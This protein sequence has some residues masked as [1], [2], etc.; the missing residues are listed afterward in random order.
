MLFIRSRKWLLWGLATALLLIVANHGEYALF[1]RAEAARHISAVNP[2][3]QQED[4]TQGHNTIGIDENTLPEEETSCFLHFSTLGLWAYERQKPVACP[5]PIQALSGQRCSS[6]G[7]MYPLDSGLQVKTFCLLRSTQ[8]CCYGPRPQWNQFLLV[9]TPVPVPLERLAPVLV[10][11]TFYVEPKPE[12]GYV[13]RMAA[14]SV[15]VIEGETPDI[16]PV[17]AAKRAGLPL[18]DYAAL[19]GLSM[20]TAALPPSLRALE[21]RTVVLAGYCVRRS[22]DVPPHLVV[23]H[24]WWDG[25]AQGEPPTVAN[26]VQV[27]PADAGQVPPLWK[28]FQVYTGRLH[29]RDEPGDWPREG[30][31]Q[32]EAAHLGAPGALPTTRARRNGPLVPWQIEA[33]LLACVLL[34]TLGWQRSLSGSAARPPLSPRYVLMGLTLILA[35]LGACSW[36]MAWTERAERDTALAGAILEQRASDVMVLLEQG[37]NPNF[38]SAALPTEKQEGPEI[39]MLLYAVQ[40]SE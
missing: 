12:D 19:S 2:A 20:Q 28:P 40:R 33:G 11:G 16:D 36:A 32:L 27:R 37:A 31:V 6:V 5:Q 4:G 38:L 30:I 21:G 22:R 34:L 15:Q 39:P 9:E 26:S 10:N 14:D 7:F 23:S 13:Y 29:I 17:V 18:F 1:C 25:V 3:V 24:A 35:S 8:T